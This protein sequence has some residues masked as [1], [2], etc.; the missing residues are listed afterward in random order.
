MEYLFSVIMPTYKNDENTL[1]RAIGSVEK[2][3]FTNWE[4]I[5]VDD[6]E[7]NDEY[8]NIT[9]SIKEKVNNSNIR[10]YFQNVNKG[11]NAA[12]NTGIKLS[13]GEF[14]AFLDGDDEWDKNYLETIKENINITHGKFYSANYRIVSKE[15]TQGLSFNKRNRKSGHIYNQEIFRDLISPTSAVVVEKDLL[16]AVGG[17]DESLPARQDYD[18]WL[19]ICKKNKVYFIYEGLVYIYRDGHFSISLNYRNHISGT[20][21]VLK[22]ILTNTDSNIYNHHKIISSHYAYIATVYLRNHVFKET[23]SY[24]FRS[25]KLSFNFQSIGLILIS[26][27]PFIVGPLQI[28]RKKI[29]YMLN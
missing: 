2:Q 21:T 11:A 20:E 6:N 23:R 18:L 17:F 1:L 16:L 15:G 27:F 26:S 10:F 13:T 12:R 7:K 3:V 9:K 5:I 8:S 19:R 24:A 25:L 22:K 4:L 29:K 28:T 14:V